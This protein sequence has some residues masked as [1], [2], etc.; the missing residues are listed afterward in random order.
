MKWVVSTSHENNY[1]LKGPPRT[2]DFKLFILYS[3]RV[4]GFKCAFNLRL[5]KLN[6][7]SLQLWGE[8]QLIK[9]LVA[10]IVK[11]KKVL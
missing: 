9:L 2:V 3:I 8:K 7:P 5:N 1:R 4:S 10:V 11:Y 6:H